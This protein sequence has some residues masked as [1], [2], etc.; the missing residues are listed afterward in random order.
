MRKLP[1]DDTNPADILKYSEELIGKTFIDILKVEFEGEELEK[2]IS[3]YNNPKSKG[4]LG[5][6]LEK[7]YY[8]Y[9]PNSKSEPD[10]LE[11]GT[12][13]KVT[14]Y[15][16]TK[17]GI[18]AGE[19]LVIT[20]IPNTEAIASKF[21]GS[22]LEKKI[23]KILM[24]W[25]HRVKSQPRTNN[26]IDFVSLYDIYS[27]I[28][29]KDLAVICDD[30]YKIASKVR[31]GKAHELSE[32][33]TK[34]L[35]ACTKGSTADKSLQPQFYNK[36][37]PAKRRAFSL[38]QSYMTYVLN[39][40]VKPGLMRYESIFSKEELENVD[41]DKQIIDKISNYVGF[42]EEYLYTKF[43]LNT[44]SKSKQIN[45][46]LVYRI[47]GINSENAEE[48]QKANI[49]VK[50]IRVKKNG[51][52]KESMS[53][54]K[55]E[56]SRF[57]EEDFEN[58]FEYTFFEETIF[59]FVVFKEN[60][61]GKYILKGSKIWNMPITELENTGKLEWESYKKK[62]ISGVNFEIGYDKTGKVI[63]KNDLPKKTEHRIF[64]LRPHAS[65]SAYVIKGIKYGNGSDK[66]MDILPNGDK[67][68]HQCF[69]L[70]NGY[71]SDIIKDI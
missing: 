43:S 59:L 36:N 39:N 49:V 51:L 48:F 45:R 56:I 11:A 47:L 22:H 41:F 25:Y 37:I 26:T 58:S 65:K 35:G 70:N 12:E 30:Y 66:D 60:E 18:R 63:V 24:V 29:E 61:E 28:F 9:L 69:W 68:T 67:M 52:P 50:T 53:F 21:K 17:K 19:R 16:K 32:S 38:K 34:Y 1:Y 62:F 42:S 5:N 40:Y 46:S 55:I 31:E 15:E 10:F 54:P 3:Y 7:Y 6:L 71:I 2:I 13:L 64:H 4:G 33:D 14:P 20:M 57:I 8:Y 23:S 27:E 44:E